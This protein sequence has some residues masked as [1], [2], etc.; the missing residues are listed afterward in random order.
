MKAI[1]ELKMESELAPLSRGIKDDSS[2]EVIDRV[3]V[4]A[5][6]IFVRLYAKYKEFETL[7]S[8]FMSIYVLY[9]CSLFLKLMNEDL[10]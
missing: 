6:K 1:S 8:M 5:T 7:T 2:R 4:M 9:I 3:N 10:Q